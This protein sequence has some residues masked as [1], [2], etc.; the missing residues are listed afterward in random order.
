MNLADARI[1]APQL[2]DQHGLQRWSL[3]FGQAQ[4]YFGI[5]YKRKRCITIS[6]PLTL[7]NDVHEVRNTI[8][9]EIAHAL[10]TDRGHGRLWKAKARLLGF[11]PERCY[12]ESVHRPPAQFVGT[13]P[14]CGYETTAHRRN[15]VS[16][17]KCDTKFNPVHLLVWTTR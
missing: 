12:P 15:R 10:T 13:C 1:L 5:C 6:A 4:S 17:G 3:V 14:T 16:C 7:L 8:L 9:H 2:M 11:R